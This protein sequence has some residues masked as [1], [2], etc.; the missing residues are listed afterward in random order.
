MEAKIQDRISKWD[1]IVSDITKMYAIL[2]TLSQAQAQYAKRPTF[3][4]SD[5]SNN[6]TRQ[7]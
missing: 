1:A 5:S 3:S 6:N 4:Q 7:E 2:A